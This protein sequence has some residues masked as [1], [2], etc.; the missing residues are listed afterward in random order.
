MKNFNNI[1]WKI[2]SDNDREAPGSAESTLKALNIAKP[3]IDS[4]PEVAD[5]ACGP[6]SSAFVLAQALESK[7]VCI[8][9]HEPFLEQIRKKASDNGNKI[10]C[11]FTG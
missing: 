1:F 11:K 10:S 6:G 3:F 4:N 5:I 2:H 8:E 9:P 7:I